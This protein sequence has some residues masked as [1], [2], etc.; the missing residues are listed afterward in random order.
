MHVIGRMGGW[1]RI[2]VPAKVSGDE[3]QGERSTG[4]FILMTMMIM[5]IT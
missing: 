3:E 4:L 5:M 2:G 1:S